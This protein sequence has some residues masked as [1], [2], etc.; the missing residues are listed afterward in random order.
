MKNTMF[1]PATLGLLLLTCTHLSAQKKGQALV[2]SLKTALPH[3]RDDTNKVIAYGQLERVWYGLN[4]DSVF[5]PAEAGLRLAEKLDYQR[6]IAKMSNNLG[7][8]ISD[9]GNSVLARQYFNK[10]Y[11]I[12]KVIGDSLNLINNLVNIGRS[13]NFEADLPHATDYLF[14]ALTIAEEI[15]NDD[16]IA[17]VGTNLTATFV[18]QQNYKKAA[19]YGKMTLAHARRANSA[20]NMF[21][22]YTQLGVI[23]AHLK[24]TVAAIADHDSAVAIADRTGNVLWRIDALLNRGEMETD[25]RK[26]IAIWHRVEKDVAAVQFGIQRRRC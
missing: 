25:S 6:G 8:F 2:D 21:R 3:M 26:R 7:L 1:L 18:K 4:H 22:A 16:M 5:A 12:N 9:T 15:K 19:E 20:N 17:L 24:D 13:Y 14:Q 10:S 11:A 23:E